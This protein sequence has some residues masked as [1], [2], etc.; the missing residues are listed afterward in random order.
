MGLERVLVGKFNVL[1]PERKPIYEC[2]VFTDELGEFADGE[3][4]VIS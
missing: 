3:F 2:G 4:G 1:V